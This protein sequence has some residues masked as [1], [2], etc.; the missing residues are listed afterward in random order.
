M[1]TK[2]S[3]SSQS[4]LKLGPV[5]FVNSDCEP[6]CDYDFSCQDTTIVRLRT[7]KTIHENMEINVMYG[8]EFFD[9]DECCCLTCQF[10]RPQNDRSFPDNLT[11]LPGKTR[12]LSRNFF[13]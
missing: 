12:K 4:Y 9:E 10:T 7:L 5:R 3:D 1:I 11:E 13:G 2:T 6:N 8:P